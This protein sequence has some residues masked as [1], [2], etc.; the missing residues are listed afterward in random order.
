MPELT[1][2]QKNKLLVAAEI[3][4]NGDLA[5]LKKI[6]EFSD[7]VEGIE[8]AVAEAVAGAEKILA[9]LEAEVERVKGI[10]KGD[11]G[12]DGRDGERGEPGE[13]G[14]PGR[15]GKDGKNGKDG[16]D[17]ADG[18]DGLDGKDGQDG[19]DGSPDT[20]EQVRDKLASLEGEERLDKK[21][22]KGL[23]EELKRIES[24]PRGGGG[25]SA[26]GVR[27]AF[28]YIFHT[29]EPA[30]DIDGVNTTYTVQNPIFAVISFSIN[31][32]TVAELPNYTIANRS[33]IFSSAIPAAYNGTDFEVKYIG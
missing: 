3:V 6:L 11:R 1:Q 19:R 27:Q 20:P 10:P 5:V 13:Q 24:L 7:S 17:G 33:I 4:E 16:N 22:I 29:E 14:E 15:P 32:E 9:D 26:L 30:G 8:K 25:V 12:D 31:G 28:K 21:H 18:R 23:D 2:E